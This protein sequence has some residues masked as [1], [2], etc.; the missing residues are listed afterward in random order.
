MWLRVDPPQQALKMREAVISPT[1]RHPYWLTLKARRAV[2]RAAF[3]CVCACAFFLL[4]YIGKTFKL[5]A[6]NASVKEK[7]K[8]KKM[9]ITSHKPRWVSSTCTTTISGKIKCSEHTDMS[10]PKGS[11]TVTRAHT[12]RQRS[13]T[14]TAVHTQ[15][16]NQKQEW[17]LDKK[18]CSTASQFILHIL[19][20]RSVIT[21]I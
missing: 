2:W 7:E 16:N 20:F 4:L 3:V 12:T 18:T 17:L 9:C 13:H 19:M 5:N 15:H 14:V 11:N 10:S 8:E 1:A 21:N 6:D